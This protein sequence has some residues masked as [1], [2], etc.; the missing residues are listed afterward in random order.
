M[1][2]LCVLKRG[3]LTQKLVAVADFPSGQVQSGQEGR[4]GLGSG[5]A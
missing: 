1:L 4:A 5:L 3:S 2:V